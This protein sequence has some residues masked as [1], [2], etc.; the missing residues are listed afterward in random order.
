MA[1]PG[2][3]YKDLQP[4]PDDE[5]AVPGTTVRP[6]GKMAANI[7]GDKP[8]ASHELATADHDLKG[9]A[10]VL[11]DEDVVDLGW[12][13]DERMRPKP[14]VGG[15]P[16]EELWLLIRRFNMQMYHVK[17]YPYPVP[18]GLDLNVA[19][20]EEFSPDKLRCNVERLYMTVIVGLIAFAKHIVRLRSWRETRRTAWF[21]TAYYTAW[22]FDVLTPLCCATILALIVYPPSREFLFPPAPIALVSSS[23]GGVQKP[24]AG[25]LGS[26]DSVTG[27]PEHHKGEAVEREASSFFNSMAAV[28]LSS[29]TGKHPQS[30]P[31]A[32]DGTAEDSAPDPTAMTLGASNARNKAGGEKSTAHQDKAKVPMETMMWTKM[33][34][35]MRIVATTADTWERLTNA[36]SPTPPFPQ[37]KHRLRL[38]A[39]VVPVLAGSFFVTPYMLLKGLT[40]GIGFGFFGDPIIMRALD[41]LN[42]KVPNWLEYLDPR[43][44]ILLGV[45]TNA[46]LTLTLL[47]IGEAN[48]APLPPP[49]RSHEAPPEVPAE[50][51]EKHLRA[52]GADAPLNASPEELNAAME[53]DPSTVHQSGGSDIDAAKDTKH[54]KKGSKILGFFKGTTRATV[55]TAI[56]ADRLKAKIGSEHAKK[57]LGAIPREGE[58]L[59]SGPVDFK[60]RYDGKKGHAYI[61]TTGPI[62]LLSFTIDSTIE[63]V[64]SQN[65]H[66]HDLDPIWTIPIAEIKELKKIGGFGWKAKLVIGWALEKEVADGLEIIDKQ[67]RSW[68]VTAMPLRD[69]LFNRLI[70]IGGQKWEAW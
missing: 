46:Q 1:R 38:A 37:D 39:L 58:D 32:K 62:P 51:S 66:D 28:L 67:G 21:C 56:G 24:K 65:L 25:V 48:K 44:N 47:R 2:V 55:E 14:L 5:L 33:R 43:N 64:G 22:F 18:G 54:G 19:A 40:F 31:P 4:V 7:L 68:T 6:R 3:H 8:T 34:P 35:L 11:R 69:E 23:T 13:E 27:A 61:R 15:L 16:N 63:K 9:A 53:H 50:V 60:A 45:P 29:A 59:T 12:H 20:E 30:E 36:L 26:H 57:R 52:T 17:E 41:L 70:A 49:P 42:R 10:Q